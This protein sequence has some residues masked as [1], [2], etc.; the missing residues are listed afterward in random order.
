MCPALEGPDTVIR[1]APDDPAQNTLQVLPGQLVNVVEHQPMPDVV[2]RVAPIQ[3]RQSLIAG[4]ALAGG[5]AVG[6]GGAAVP[7]R[8]C[9]NGVAISV[10]GVEQQTV[11][12][13]M[14]QPSLQRMVVGID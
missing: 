1:P 3:A 6:S 4:E 9:V 8:P 12:H 7:G 10:V 13:L 14:L 11:A 2:D 5:R